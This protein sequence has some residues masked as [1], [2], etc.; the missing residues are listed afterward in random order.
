MIRLASKYW[1]AFF[2]LHICR[3]A[4][5]NMTSSQQIPSG[6]VKEMCNQKGNTFLMEM[7]ER[8]Y[9]DISP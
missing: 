5:S 6:D 1:L 7:L 4:L 2:W 3:S 9:L 8:V